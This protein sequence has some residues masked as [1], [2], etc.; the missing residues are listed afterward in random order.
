MG[1]GSILVLD[2]H[3]IDE[4]RMARIDK[5]QVTELLIEQ[6]VGTQAE[7]ARRM[8]MDYPHLNRI[9]NGRNC[10]LET[11]GR[12]ARVLRCSPKYLITDDPELD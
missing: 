9:L 8:K 4:D 5:V 7:L 3:P 11:I 12:M 1:V 2:N 6:G 10:T